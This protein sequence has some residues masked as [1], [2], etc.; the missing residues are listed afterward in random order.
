MTH[1]LHALK[2]ALALSIFCT[3]TIW[4][5]TDPPELDD[6][7]REAYKEAAF[8]SK[9]PWARKYIHV[10]RA[11]SVVETLKDKYTNWGGTG[12]AWCETRQTLRRFNPI[13]WVANIWW[14][15]ISRFPLGIQNIGWTTDG[16]L[17][18]KD[19]RKARCVT[20]EQVLLIKDPCLSV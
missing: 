4:A 8:I 1:D 13:I 15:L 11:G 10:G 12:L 9:L 18:K 16:L 14:A 20:P 6:G 5:L 3:R 7:L 17:A 2:A 19:D